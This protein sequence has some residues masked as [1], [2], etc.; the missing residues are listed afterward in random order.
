[1]N[2]GR[3]QPRP[4]A[5]KNFR[6]RKSPELRSTMPAKILSWRGDTAARNTQ[7]E[8]Q[9]QLTA[10]FRPTSKRDHGAER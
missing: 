2:R 9:D 4:A 6:E 3:E 1:M 8:D 5:R 10:A 7:G